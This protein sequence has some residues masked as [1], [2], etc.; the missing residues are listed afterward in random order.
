M[1]CWWPGLTNLWR[2]WNSRSPVWS[3]PLL[4][5]VVLSLPVEYLAAEIF[6]ERVFPPCVR[7]GH[8]V[9]VTFTGS[10][11]GGASALWSSAD[12][13]NAKLIA[14]DSDRVTF[15]IR[16]PSEAPV[17]MYGFRV[18]THSGLSNLH[19][20]AIDDLPIRSEQETVQ[21]DALNDRP[22]QAQPVSLPAV[23]VGTSR[24]SDLDHFAINVEAGQRIAFEV[25]GS[26]LG[27][28]FDP[29]ITILDER[30]RA[31][32]TYDN[33]PGLFFDFRF[34]HTFESAG[35]YVLRLHDSR[36]YGSE[37]WTYMLR[38]GRFPESRVAL[39]STV[40]RHT[41]QLVSFPGFADTHREVSS[42]DANVT[43]RFYFGLRGAEDD[44]PVWIPMQIST[45][46][47]TV[48]A[49]PNDDTKTAAASDIP[50]NLHG[51]FD[52]PGD[53]DWFQFE[54]QKGTVVELRSETR[55]IGSPADIELAVFDADAKRLTSSDDSDFDDAR[56]TFEAPADGTFYLQV[57]EL[58]RKFGTPY[59]YRV[60]VATRRPQISVSAGTARLT[61][62]RSTRQPLPLI[63]QRTDFD[64]P[65]ELSLH[66][67]PAGMTLHTSEIASEATELTTALV[68]DDSVPPGLH[69]I[70]VVATGTA[71]ESSVSAV[72]ATAPL[73][74]RV[75]TERGPHGEAFELREDQRRLPPTVSDRIAV[76]VVPESPWDFEI[77]EHDVVVPRYIQANF[78]IRTTRQS[79]YDQPVTFVARGGLLERDR[80]REASVTSWIP[81]A[82]LDASEVVG[83]LKSGVDTLLKR[84]RVTV[85]GSA[86][87]G[88]RLLHL[89]R[90]F[91]LETKSA[92][93]LSVEIPE[94][95]LS[96]GGR[97]AVKI[98]SH[99]LSPFADQISLKLTATDG[100]Q[101]PE[102]LTI[103]SGED[104]VE[105]D[106]VLD[107]SV[108]PG[109]YSVSVTGDAII[110]KFL[111]RVEGE[112][113]TVVVNE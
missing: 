20:F 7:R 92:Y 27:K 37:R 8:T 39:P 94:I 66:G 52:V 11:L 48:E 70:R 44:A 41:R 106:L 79:G 18:A 43:D 14:A 69:T 93:R 3:V 100:I 35:R 55:A 71:D 51:S 36:Y 103:L 85:T 101:V 89:T 54:L 86:R 19:L 72:A 67:A 76:L 57:T 59:T 9:R 95:Q 96:P 13:V 63:V 10:E 68:V 33:D 25:V 5:V 107:E 49:E 90:T 28:A 87:D 60:E 45:W 23:V 80:L 30:G 78:T 88:G 50:G 83:V 113:L 53:E 4:T 74:D 65:I 61:I 81:E 108:K 111:E 2:M 97:T 58:V 29:V 110:G 104:S 99:R 102:M 17:G 40:L 26:R 105:F 82:T 73:V 32:R 64:G 42:G 22:A 16:T 62:P 56:L 84:H 31:V 38:I 24:Q 75:P 15:D 21:A 109:R 46:P 6:V 1:C 91:Q 34:S 77:V 47:S 12:F 98:V 112:P